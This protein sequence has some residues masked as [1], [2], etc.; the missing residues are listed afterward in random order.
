MASPTTAIPYGRP[1]QGYRLPDAT[2][3]G[4]VTLQVADLGR[5][6]DYY[7]Q[8]IGLRVLDRSGGT[9]VLGPAGPPK[10]APIV[11]LR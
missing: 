3:L 1:P 7:E 11:E 9:A 6:L 2:R 4:Q 8:V 10:A 5:S